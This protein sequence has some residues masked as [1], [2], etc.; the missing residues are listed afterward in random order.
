MNNKPP[1]P[2]RWS[3]LTTRERLAEFML[4]S[5]TIEGII[6]LPTIDE[7]IATEEFLLANATVETV[8]DLQAVYAP[9]M[10][11]RNRPG[12]DV[13]VGKHIPMRGN[14]YMADHL[15]HALNNADPWALHVAFEVLHP[16]MDGNGRTGRTVWAW[17]MLRAGQD[18]FALPFLHRFYYQTLEHAE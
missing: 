17:A 1:S 8:I 12:M 11:L 16:F 15:E 2:T 4:E 9:G 5:L 7:L 10:P 13:R 14:Q 18:P 6:R 3:H